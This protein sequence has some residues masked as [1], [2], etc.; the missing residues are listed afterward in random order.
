[1]AKCLLIE[2]KLPKTLWVYALMAS[3]YI[4]NCYYN[5]NTRKA[6]MESFTSSKPNLNKMRIFGT[7]C[8]C[9]V[10]NKMKLDPCCQK[11]IFVGYDKKSPAYLIYFLKSTATK[12]VRYAKFTDSYDN[13]PQMK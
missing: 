4:R 12:R 2:S 5:K 11:S 8:F 9:Y 3:A 10:Q 13:S 7:T 1:M 6:P